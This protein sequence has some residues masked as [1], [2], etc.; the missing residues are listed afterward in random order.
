MIEDYTQGSSSDKSEPLE[1]GWSRKRKAVMQ[2]AEA[3]G[4]P[5]G[6]TP[7]QPTLSQLMPPPVPQNSIMQAS[8]PDGYEPD[9]IPTTADAPS[10]ASLPSMLGGPMTQS[11]RSQQQQQQ[12]HPQFENTEGIEITPQPNELVMFVPMLATTKKTVCKW[13]NPRMRVWIREEMSVWDILQEMDLNA[14]PSVLYKYCRSLSTKERLLEAATS[15]YGSDI[16]QFVLLFIRETSSEDIF[17]GILDNNH[18]ALKLYCN[19]LSALGEYKRLLA[20]YQ[21]F[22]AKFAEG[23]LLLRE[24]FKQPDPRKRVS[25]F[26][27]SEMFFN[28]IRNPE[29][30]QVSGAG[31][32]LLERQIRIEE[33]D[34]KVAER[35]DDWIYRRYPPQ[36]IVFGSVADTIYYNEFYHASVPAGK[37][38]SPVGMARDFDVSEKKR[39][40]LALR[41]RGMLQDWDYLRQL[42]EKRGFF[43]LKHKSKIGFHPFVEV[44]HMYQAPMEVMYHFI[45]LIKDK[46]DRIK[47]ASQ[48]QCYEALIETFKEQ[49]DYGA[50]QELLQF[51]D[52]DFAASYMNGVHRGKI[53]ETLSNPDI[54]WKNVPKPPKTR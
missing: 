38:S 43:S 32:R 28:Q 29:W 42:T 45:M 51:L 10:L 7:A 52:G 8:Q 13:K 20:V 21:R 1:F 41:A 9:N 53:M 44:C 48:Y 34:A 47:I 14:D 17:A 22:N 26:R 31:A 24:A 46:E 49:R 23:K 36:S 50:M 37:L 35:G 5:G 25:N 54:K 12:P 6:P 19:Y 39:L 18:P 30:A 4:I 40:W 16:V 3:N 15:M 33:F 27:Y 2:N 11:S